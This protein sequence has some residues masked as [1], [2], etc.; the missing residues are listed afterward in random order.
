MA[1]SSGPKTSRTASAFDALVSLRKPSNHSDSQ[2]SDHLYVSTANQPD[3]EHPPL[4]QANLAKSVDPTYIKFTTY[5]R[6]STHRAVKV[7][8][9]ERDEELSDLV[10]QLLQSWL[11]ENK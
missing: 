5:V 6:K 4:A 7:K 2:T 9:T 1:K 11:E 3:I 8:L 10:E